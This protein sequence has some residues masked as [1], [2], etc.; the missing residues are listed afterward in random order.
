MGAQVYINTHLSSESHK[1]GHTHTY[2]PST[3]QELDQ[4]IITNYSFCSVLT[5]FDTWH[6]SYNNIG[7]QNLFKPYIKN[8][9]TTNPFPSNH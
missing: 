9:T 4:S 3:T 8:K 6:E 5:Y 2:L 1:N 7:A